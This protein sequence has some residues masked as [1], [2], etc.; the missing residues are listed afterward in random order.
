MAGIVNLN[1]ARKD[2]ARAGKKTRAKENRVRFGRTRIDRQAEEARAGK[3]ARDLAGHR[4]NEAG[5]LPDD[6][7]E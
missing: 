7:Q 5:R 2:K 3:S 1:K 4:L 6:E